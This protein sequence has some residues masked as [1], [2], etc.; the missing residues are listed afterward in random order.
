MNVQVLPVQE[1]KVEGFELF[2]L[3]FISYLLYHGVHQLLAAPA[4]PKPH[5]TKNQKRRLCCPVSG[6]CSRESGRR[7]V[8]QGRQKET[9]DSY[10]FFIAHRLGNENTHFPLPSCCCLEIRFFSSM[11]CPWHPLWLEQTGKEQAPWL[12]LGGMTGGGGY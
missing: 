9:F 7:F 8:Q 1:L 2:L 11:K 4:N 10:P 12:P 6:R 3:E 5:S